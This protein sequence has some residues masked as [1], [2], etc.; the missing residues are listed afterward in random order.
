VQKSRNIDFKLALWYNISAFFEWRVFMPIEANN[1]IIENKD[2][3]KSKKFDIEK[4]YF[5]ISP[6]IALVLMIIV[7]LPYNNIKIENIGYFLAKFAVSGVFF[8]SIQYFFAALFS[9]RLLGFL[10]TNISFLILSVA[11]SLMMTI[12]GTPLVPVDFVMASQLDDIS[13]FINLPIKPY[14]VWGVVIWLINML[15]YTLMFVYLR[16]KK[17]FSFKKYI[18]RLVVL[19]VIASLNI[20]LM[21]FNKTFKN[22]FLASIKCEISGFDTASNYISNGFIL[23][24]FPRIGD[25]R[26]K[27]PSGY[28]KERI[29]ELE[30]ISEVMKKVPD[31]ISEK[32]VNVI[33]IQSESWWDPTLFE[34]VTMSDDPMKNIRKLGKEKNGFFGKM[35][36]PSFGCNTCIPEFE[37]LTSLATKLLPEG[38]YPYSQYVRKPVYSIARI[39]KENGYKT[40]AI[41][42]YYKKFYNRKTA[43]PFMGFDELIGQE[44]LDK[45]VKKGTY[46]SDMYLTDVIIDKFNQKAGNPLFLYAISMQNH[47]NYLS[48]RYETYD[49]DVNS[50][51]LSKED[52]SGLREAVQGVYDIDKSFMALVDYFRKSDEPTLLIMYGDHLPFLGINSSTYRSVGFMK[53]D[54]LVRNKNMYETPYVI[55]ANYDIS[56]FDIKER[57]GAQYLG[58]NAVK[59]AM[60]ENLP[61]QFDFFDDFYTNHT[62]FERYSVCDENGGYTNGSVVTTEET[63]AYQMVQYDCLFGKENYAV[64]K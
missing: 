43:Y 39:F 9:N 22:D 55:W 11:S 49:I 42:T 28:S 58:I 6:V 45:P 8:C 37:F 17:K 10:L 25:L 48:P 27:A 24:F 23:T 54:L 30:T 18:L 46:I 12:T 33:A 57:V 3:I 41:H 15:I 53:H 20:H 21:C 34:N 47:G 31:K 1:D 35:V 59:M 32:K 44:D 7:Q 60:V 26:I 2:K 38:A 40:S 52:L 50:N 61:W 29:K 19:F 64:S 13:T 56:G 51:V 16:R 62:V 4:F 36:S 5:S 63:E 14:L